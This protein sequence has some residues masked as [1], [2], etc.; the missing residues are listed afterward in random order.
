MRSDKE[1][2]KPEIV[3]AEQ[4]YEYLEQIHDNTRSFLFEI[5]PKT[6]RKLLNIFAYIVIAFSFFSTICVMSFLCIK[7]HNM[8]G[9][10]I[11]KLLEKKLASHTDNPHFVAPCAELEKFDILVHSQAFYSEHI[12]LPKNTLKLP[13]MRLWNVR[14]S[15]LIIYMPTININV[16]PSI[17]IASSFDHTVSDTKPYGLTQLLQ[18]LP[19]APM[20]MTDTTCH[21]FDDNQQ[22]SIPHVNMHI[23]TDH[24]MKAAFSIANATCEAYCSLHPTIT[25]PTLSITISKIN[26]QHLAHSL[27]A[28]GIRNTN[29]IAMRLLQMIDADIEGTIYVDLKQSQNA[30]EYQKTR[31]D[32]KISTGKIIPLSE[33]SWHRTDNN[34]EV[35]INNGH[36][37]GYIDQNGLTINELSLATKDND[38]TFFISNLVIHTGSNKSYTLDGEVQIHNLPSTVLTNFINVAHLPHRKLLCTADTTIAD[39]KAHATSRFN[40]DNAPEIEL[41]KCTFKTISSQRELFRASLHVTEISGDINGENASMKE[42]LGKYISPHNHQIFNAQWTGTMQPHQRSLSIAYQLPQKDLV[43]Y[44][45]S[46]RFSF[47][48]GQ[49]LSTLMTDDRNFAAKTEI[50]RTDNSMRVMHI[51]ESGA[52]KITQTDQQIKLTYQNGINN[53]EICEDLHT[54]QYTVAIKGTFPSALIANALHITPISSEITIQ[55]TGT[56]SNMYGLYTIQTDTASILDLHNL[57]AYTKQSTLSFEYEISPSCSTMRNISILSQNAEKEDEIRGDISIAQNNEIIAMNLSSVNNRYHTHLSPSTHKTQLLQSEP[58][59]ISLICDEIHTK[60]ILAIVEKYQNTDIILHTQLLKTEYPVQ[61]HRFHGRIKSYNGKI[62][63]IDGYGC[64]DHQS[65]IVFKTIKPH[66]FVISA[67]DAEHLIKKMGIANSILDGTLQAT[68][69]NLQQH[70]RGRFSLKNFFIH[71]NSIL[72]KMIALSSPTIMTS[73][74]STIG[75]NMMNGEFALVDERLVFN[76][77]TMTGPVVAISAAGYYDMQT[78]NSTISGLCIPLLNTHNSL[79]AT[80]Q[81]ALTLKEAHPHL[82]VYIQKT[83]SGTELKTLFP[84]IHL[85][86]LTQTKDNTSD[87]TTTSQNNFGVKIITMNKNK[88]QSLAQKS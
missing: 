67:I 44:Y 72:L 38:S 69:N 61:I 50:H 20:V 33:N 28:F 41:H 58:A 76:N 57:P 3:T 8:I 7:Q 31:F 22:F 88:P 10:G 68:V 2:Q 6:C 26:A 29:S 1:M 52:C 85:P 83:V 13:I 55:A 30:L 65:S 62:T 56:Y 54:Q 86:T 63:H 34:S 15:E 74:D 60:D 73:S 87:T 46:P 19:K 82:N 84:N 17:T 80:A 53:L 59:K 4:N 78:R 49:A 12:T 42:G 51:F 27:A 16:S 21:I 48:F 24:V 39:L 70:I 25:S 11:A 40:R 37:I 32:F 71:N 35:A 43:T 18:I 64:H 81:Y 9:Q 36:I 75:F 5:S 77:V 45:Q 14:P 47:N 23:D 66:I 79:F